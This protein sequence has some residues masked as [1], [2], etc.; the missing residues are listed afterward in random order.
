MVAIACINQSNKIGAKG[1][2]MYDNKK[3]MKI[4]KEL[5]TG[6][7]VIMGRKTWESL[8]VK[9]LPGRINLV[10]SESVEEKEREDLKFFHSKTT[11]LNWIKKNHPDKEAYVI[12]G[13]TVYELLI[14]DCN[15]AIIT[16]VE[17]DQVYGDTYFP[18]DIYDINRWRKEH[19]IDCGYFTDRNSGKMYRW[20]VGIFNNT[21]NETNTDLEELRKKIKSIVK[22]S[23]Y[24]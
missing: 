20:N 5:T 16:K 2:L 24:F 21:Q 8:P 10:L 6:N 4:F 23:S 11:L 19:N 17:D 14:N 13:G 18:M 22:P 7:I 1:K 3:D 9:P 12:G 15:Y